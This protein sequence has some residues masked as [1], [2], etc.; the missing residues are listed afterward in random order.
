MESKRKIFARESKSIPVAG[1]VAI[2]IVSISQKTTF[3]NQ[4]KVLIQ[5]NGD[6]RFESYFKTIHSVHVLHLISR[7]AQATVYK[8]TDKLILVIRIACVRS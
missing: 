8:Q 5:L 7:E 1:T 6:A 2:I 4:I 3:G